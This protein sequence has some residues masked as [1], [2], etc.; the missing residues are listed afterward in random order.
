MARELTIAIVKLLLIANSLIDRSRRLKETF[1]AI[2]LLPAWR[3]SA[4]RVEFCGLG[5]L[6]FLLP[7]DAIGQSIDVRR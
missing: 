2:R 5:L 7:R 6:I 4:M 3:R 1:S